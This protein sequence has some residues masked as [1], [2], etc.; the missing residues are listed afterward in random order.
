MTHLDLSAQPSVTS[1]TQKYLRVIPFACNV[2]LVILW[3]WLFRAVF[4][5]LAII[6]T[7]ED[8]RTN[9]L[10][11][12]GVIVLFA[13]QFRREQTFPQLDAAPQ[14]HRA[15]LLLVL[16]GSIGYLLVERFL[17]INTISA[18]LFG[19]ASYG[20]IGLWLNPI[21]WRA[22][23][24]AALLV[25]GILPFGDHMQTFIGYP[26]RILT[27]SLV[28]DGLAS[29]GVASIGVDTILV[30]ENGVSQ[31]D[32]PCSGVKSLW[33]GALFL[34][35]ATWI[36]RRPINLRWFIIASVFALLLFV[37]NFARVAILV[38]VGQVLNLQLVAEMMHVPLGV[39]GFIA[40]C[41]AGALMLRGDGGRRTADGGQTTLVR[42]PYF[43]VF[44][45]TTFLMLGLL[46]SPRPQTGLAQART[47]N[48]PGE[49]AVQPLPLNPDE[50]AALTRENAESADR[51]QFAWRGITGSMI[52]VPSATWRAQHRPERCLEVLGWQIN[53]SRAVL[54]APDFPVRSV[55][56]NQRAGSSLSA[57]YWF[58]SA[59]R[60]TDDY[61]TRMWADLTPQRERWVLVSVLFDRTLD[62]NDENV[63]SFYLALRDAMNRNL[64]LTIDN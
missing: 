28:R 60:V 33:T 3:L 56:V 7:R 55:T 12:V 22:G 18:S 11:L 51:F 41:A 34:L 49:L 50:I 61:G 13:I 53:N 17:D 29:A 4:D 42:V 8:F 24:P 47:W 27:A 2:A 6:F 44:L 52:L 45:A 26:M 40:A 14:P 54:I 1:S 25:I 9:Q 39:L 31:V 30:F 48:F 58:Q 5:Y 21:R 20:L 62:P 19:L 35:A 63:Q 38:I 36:E 59:T 37:T 15:P 32:L 64:Q 43:S 46:Y 10:A 57:T 23:L 16:A